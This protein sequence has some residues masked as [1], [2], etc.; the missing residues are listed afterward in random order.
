MISCR[1]CESPAVW[2]VV[3]HTGIK[4]DALV[5]GEHVARY[6]LNGC[7]VYAVAISNKARSEKSED[8][9]PFID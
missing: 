6:L 3:D 7:C 8:L 2:R 9:C 1:K 5:C 4:P